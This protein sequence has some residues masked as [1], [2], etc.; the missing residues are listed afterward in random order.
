MRISARL[1][2]LQLLLT[3]ALV[4]K[5]SFWRKLASAAAA[6]KAQLG[7]SRRRCCFRSGHAGDVGLLCSADICVPSL[8]GFLALDHAREGVHAVPSTR[9]FHETRRSQESLSC[10]GRTMED[11]A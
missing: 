6:A 5:Q 1:A 8:S 7:S 10:V 4:T 2:L 9:D 11:P 3:C